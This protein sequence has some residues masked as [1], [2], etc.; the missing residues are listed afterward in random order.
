[1]GQLII[2]SIHIGKVNQY[3]VD[4][5]TS[6]TDSKIQEFVE[7][8]EKANQAAQDLVHEEEEKCAQEEAKMDKKE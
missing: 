7:K 5:P 1:M 6:N 3:F 2:R 4:D 8:T